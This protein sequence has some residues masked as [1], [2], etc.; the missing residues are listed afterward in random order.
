MG[1]GT[2][3]NSQYQGFPRLVWA[4]WFWKEVDD[5]SRRPEHTL[6]G[7]KTSPY[8]RNV[9]KPLQNAPPWVLTLNLRPLVSNWVRG[10]SEGSVRGSPHPS[11]E[12]T[13]NYS[14]LLVPHPSTGRRG[15][16][17]RH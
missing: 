5:S 9:P 10:D 7:A 15:V 17:R 16:S 4:P 1:Q 2:Q 6:P 13:L 3:F 8:H 14:D 12:E 11:P